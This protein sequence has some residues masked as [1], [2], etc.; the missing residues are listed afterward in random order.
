MGYY[1]KVR[2]CS[3]KENIKELQKELLNRDYSLAKF[4]EEVELNDGT[5]VIGW[6]WIK[7]YPEYEEVTF[8]TD[9]MYSWK[10]YEFARTGEDRQD[11]EYESNYDY[12][13]RDGHL[14]I[15]TEIDIV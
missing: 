3:K 11:I 6:D 1:S 14:D 13:E 15:I 10:D 5:M 12:D 7:W 9:T 8:V 2:I 4:D